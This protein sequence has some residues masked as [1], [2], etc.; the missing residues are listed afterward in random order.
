MLAFVVWK[1]AMQ[2]GARQHRPAHSAAERLAV[3]FMSPAPVMSCS[4]TFGCH[5]T[6]D[7]QL[8]LGGAAAATAASE[9][10]RARSA[11]GGREAGGREGARGAPGRGGELGTWGPPPWPK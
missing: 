6:P 3:L 2:R 5:R 9:A 1:K 8:G 7:S 11:I 10:S 4:W